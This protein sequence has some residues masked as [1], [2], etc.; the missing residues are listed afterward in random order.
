VLL[1]ALGVYLPT[2]LNGNINMSYVIID[3]VIIAIILMYFF[4]RTFKTSDAINRFNAL[5]MIAILLFFT[6]TSQFG[7]HITYNILF[8]YLL[9][10]LMY[11]IDFSRIKMAKY[12][13]IVFVLVNTLNLV[14]SFGII[15]GIKNISDFVINHYSDFY[16]VLV[17]YLVLVKLQPV[18]TFATHSL[19]GF[20]MYMFFY[21]NLE[22]YKKRKNKPLFLF[23]MLSYCVFLFALK[24]VTSVLFLIVAIYQFFKAI[25]AKWRIILIILCICAIL[26]DMNSFMKFLNTISFALSSQKNGFSGRYS[27]GGI[28]TNNITYLTHHIFSPLGLRYS[29]GE[30]FYGDS[31]ILDNLLRGSIFLLVSV[32]G[33]L[34]RFL[35][36]NIKD[37]SI[38]L[39][40]FVCYF[41]F[42]FGFSNI[43]Y[44]RDLY[45]L[46]FIIVYLNSL[47]NDDDEIRIF[48]KK[49]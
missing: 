4:I 45:F 1:I 44:F 31:G 42:E 17:P 46:P 20:Y 6:L 39:F 5:F 48:P 16:S 27:S 25:R 30:I 23:F 2:S 47:N 22:S 13:N 38:S 24:S 8:T 40:V 3:E 7:N 33:G 26:T 11:C 9:I 49:S 32:Y 12:V 18:L 36:I 19:A 14:I 10:G 43:L 41:I 35:R 21:L 29:I 37:R 28:Y 15:F 34:Y